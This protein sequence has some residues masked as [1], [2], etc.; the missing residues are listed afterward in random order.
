MSDN[1]T[2]GYTTRMSGFRPLAGQDYFLIPFVA[3]APGLVYV[4][5]ISSDGAALVVFSLS[6]FGFIFFFL[7][8]PIYHSR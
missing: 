2:V 3:L 6:A 7:L 8:V 1:E 5:G 4:I